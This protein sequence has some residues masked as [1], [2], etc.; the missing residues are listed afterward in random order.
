M[1]GYQTERVLNADDT[2][3]ANLHGLAFPHFASIFRLC[4]RKAGSESH[5]LND[6]IIPILNLLDENH[7]YYMQVAK[8]I[9]N[10]H[11]ISLFLN[12]QSM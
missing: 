9:G 1:C 10:A 4:V 8:P 3:V 7:H 2:S 5:L 12:I 6:E 11:Y